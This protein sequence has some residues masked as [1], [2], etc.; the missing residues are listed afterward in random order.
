MKTK[1]IAITAAVLSFFTLSNSYGAS[2]PATGDI[3]FSCSNTPPTLYP[4]PTPAPASN[5]PTSPT[6]T[7]IWGIASATTVVSGSFEG[8]SLGAVIVSSL[9]FSHVSLNR[10]TGTLSFSFSGTTPYPTI[11]SSPHGV[12]ASVLISSVSSTSGVNG[13]DVVSIANGTT[14]RGS[15]YCT[16]QSACPYYDSLIQSERAQEASCSVS[17]NPYINSLESELATFTRDYN[18][19]VSNGGPASFIQQYANYVASTKA[20]IA[21]YNKNPQPYVTQCQAAAAAVVA[22]YEAQLKNVSCPAY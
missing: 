10:Q 13:S 11:S 22:N 17:N 6:L 9:S 21:A 15:L 12:S 4:T 20:S 8:F 16:L 1:I 7:G 19:W 14:E 3:M 5:S 18:F 2:L